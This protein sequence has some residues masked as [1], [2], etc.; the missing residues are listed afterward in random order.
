MMDIARV[1]KAELH[2]HIEGTFEPEQ[3]FT[4]AERN[5]V[6][7]PYSTVA[8]LEA[9][10]KFANLQS[11]LDL[12]YAAMTV[13]RTERDFEELT[14]AYLKRAQ[15]QNVKHAEIFFDP[16]AHTQ[17]GIAFET[18]LD[19]LWSALLRSERDFGI[20]TKLIMCFL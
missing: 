15:A 7:L 17:R 12:Y 16:Q 8:D 11:F 18:V 2:V 5:A 19:G 1:P 13:L 4:F 14:L 10:Y 3:I 9:A 6:T 20:T